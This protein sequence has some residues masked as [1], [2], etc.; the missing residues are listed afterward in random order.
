MIRNPTLLFVFACFLMI[1]QWLMTVA[2]NGVTYVYVGEERAPAAVKSLNDYYPVSNKYLQKSA[3]DQLFEGVRFM[4]RENELGVGVGN[5]IL[6]D[7]FGNRHFACA[8]QGR[9]GVFDRVELSFVGVGVSDNGVIPKMIVDSACEA[10]DDF[11][12]LSPIWI[13]M[14]EIY[15]AD[16]KT[17]E[18]QFPEFGSTAIHFQN[19]ASSWPDKWTLVRVRLYHSSAKVPALLLEPRKAS[20]GTL[21]FDWAQSK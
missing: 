14:S 9:P 8:T 1:G 20:F 19:L 16:P 6:P 17:Q 7:S 10:E 3:Q 18:L 5:V 21:S 12:S 2:W 4:N 11:S 15:Q 13:P